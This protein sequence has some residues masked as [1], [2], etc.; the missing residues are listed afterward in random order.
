M[1]LEETLQ[2]GFIFLD[3]VG[4][5]KYWSARTRDLLATFIGAGLGDRL[6]PALA[7]HIARLRRA[8]ESAELPPLRRGGATLRLK[9]VRHPLHEGFL[10]VVE[11]KATP[12][13]TETLTT[14]ERE[15]LDWL[16]QGKANSEIGII[17]GISTHTVKRHVEHVLSKLGVESRFS[18]AL[19]SLGQ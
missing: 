5:V 12:P 11:E 2:R 4:E 3:R 17:L 18:A 7:S 10:I 6:P 16:G 13:A 9:F 8:G 15:V 14:R 1:S 19:V